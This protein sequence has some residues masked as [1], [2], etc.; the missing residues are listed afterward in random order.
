MA[1]N[2]VGTWKLVLVERRADD[3]TFSQPLGETPVGRLTYT[4]D[5]Y[6]Q[7]ILM[8]GNRAAFDSCDLYGTSEERQRGAE[9]AAGVRNPPPDSSN[10]YASESP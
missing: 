7:A 8:P 5:G 10:F 6:M 1:E 4:N 9:H 2:I 3:G